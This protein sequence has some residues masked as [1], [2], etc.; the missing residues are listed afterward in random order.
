LTLLSVAAG[1]AACSDKSEAPPAPP[2][3]A[4]SFVVAERRDVPVSFEF[5]AQTRSPRQVDIHARVPG[6]LERR[7]FTEG[8]A[9]KAG[10]LL[11]VIDPRPF[12]AQVR[13]A[14]AALSR[15]D[16]GLVTAR[17]TLDRV[18]PLAEKNALSRKDL[19]DAN[20]QVAT[21]TAS[22]DQARAQV[23]AAQLDLSYTRVTSP[24]SGLVGAA[25]VAEGTY[26]SAQNS[27]LTTVSVLSP[28]RVHFSLSE[29]E[30]QRY[31]SD[32]AKGR[33]KPPP[34]N[35]YVVEVVLGDG[36]ALPQTGQTTFTDPSFNA[37]TGTFELRAEVDNPD[38]AL[39]PNQFVRARVRGAVRPG[40]V[41]VPQRAVQQGPKGAFVWV[42]AGERVEM[43]PV[44]PGDWIDDRSVHRRG[45]Q[46][47]RAGG[48]RWRHAA[49]GRHDGESQALDAEAA[50][51]GAVGPGRAALTGRRQHMS[52][53]SSSSG[54][55][56]PPSSPCCSA[57][58]AW[59]PCWCCRCSS[60]HHHAGAGHR[61][62]HLPGAIAHP[63]RFGGGTHRG[64]DH[65]RREHAL[66]EAPPARPPASS[67]MHPSS[68]RS[69]PNRRHRAGAGA[70][71]RRPGAAATAGRGRPDGRSGCRRSPRRS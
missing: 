13:Q 39:R 7:A 66:H 40:A 64:A 59:P 16:A 32:V 3:P 70:E 57:W 37:R 62:R 63:C 29:N 52:R 55:C 26:V 38:L 12:E 8:A 41:A 19:D 18:R 2:A 60:I 25:V 69:T 11:F 1:L 21:Q 20:G 34:G 15:N 43:R 14:Q 47:R 48:G 17:A 35:R 68:G 44:V 4:V 67:P 5:V 45:P 46:G 53:A 51:A 31:R 56:S 65:R 24:V 23:E 27:L 30:S 71:P 6:F 42:L 54:R 61:Q 10:D 58:P 36:T 9:V 22:V 50:R 33:L 49:R 28:M